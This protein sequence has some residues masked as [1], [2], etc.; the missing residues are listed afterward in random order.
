MLEEHGATWGDKV[1][2][3]GVSSDQDVNKLKNHIAT[4]GWTKP[5]HYWKNK[6]DC[7]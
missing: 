7:S 4:K 1:K 6:S 2:I 3:I 5:I